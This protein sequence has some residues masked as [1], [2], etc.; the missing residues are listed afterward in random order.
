MWLVPSILFLS[1][2]REKSGWQGSIEIVDGVTIVKNPAEPILGEFTFDLEEDLVIGGRI[3]EDNYY[4][5][6]RISLS[7]DDQGNIFVLDTGNYRVQKYDSSGSH[8]LSIGRQ[9]QGPG[10]L[11]SPS[12]LSLDKK[13]NLWIF[14]SGARGIKVFAK[15]GQHLK[16]LK[17][18]TFI[19]P[20]VFISQ[21]GFIFG[22][23]DEYRSPDGPKESILKI[24]PE[25]SEVETVAEFHGEQKSNQP[26]FAIH[27]YTTRLVMCPLNPDA[28]CYGHSSEYKIYVADG[29]GETIRI[30][31][32]QEEPTP[33]T[34]SEKDMTVKEGIYA[35]IGLSR[36]PEDGKGVV[37]PSHRP[38]FSRMIADDRGR[39]YVSRHPSI[40]DKDGPKEFDVF[41]E[42]GNY[43]YRIELPF[44]PASIKDGFLYEIREDEDTGEI[45]IVRHKVLNWEGD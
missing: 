21:E 11:R 44:F 33:I 29:S 4:F 27:F 38:Y 24:H 23:K 20:Q 43:L 34:G 41:A 7:V 1:C 36:P 39:L 15:D 42:E 30:I 25:D 14:D 28:F 16:S 22:R 32:K 37:F 9:G 10:E 18:M 6:R 19:Q 12:Y 35:M 26:W 3:D 45:T 2:G 5:P 8:L 17:I 31:E 13:G 40:L